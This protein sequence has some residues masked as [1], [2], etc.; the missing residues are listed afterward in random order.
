MQRYEDDQQEL[1]LFELNIETWRQLWRVLEFSDILLIIVDVRFSVSSTHL[2]TI[3]NITKAQ[4]IIYN[5]VRIT[6]NFINKHLKQ[7]VIVIVRYNRRRVFVFSD[8]N[9]SAFP[10]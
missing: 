7:L 3:N 8:V 10:L 4:C 6:I 2:T 1:S 9:V 5:I